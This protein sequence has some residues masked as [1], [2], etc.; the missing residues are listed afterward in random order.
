ML[1]GLFRKR[2]SVGLDAGSS[3]VKVVELSGKD[4]HL[5]LTGLGTEPLAC[6][7]V[8][9]GQIFNQEEMAGAI[10]KLFRQHRLDAQRLATGIGGDPTIR[11]ILSTLLPSSAKVRF[12]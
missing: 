11:E 3:C 9:D 6:D 10:S 2:R 5:T 7:T 1:R 4:N 12:A 8:I